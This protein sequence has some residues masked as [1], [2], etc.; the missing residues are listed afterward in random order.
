M[1]IATIA[2]PAGIAGLIAA[3]EYLKVRNSKWDVLAQKFRNT[4][5]PPKGWRG[6]RFLRVEIQEGNRM[7]LTTYSHSLS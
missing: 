4:G 7:R 2:I 5:T 1:N 3:S 6:C